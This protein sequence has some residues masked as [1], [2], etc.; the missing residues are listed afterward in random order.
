MTKYESSYGARRSGS[1]QRSSRN[2]EAAVSMA[3]PVAS[4]LG[5]SMQATRWSSRGSSR[6]AAH[7]EAQKAERRS[8]LRQ[9]N[10]ESYSSDKTHREQRGTSKM[11]RSRTV[12]RDLVALR[13]GLDTGASRDASDARDESRP[14]RRAGS[15]HVS[16]TT[17]SRTTA[18]R[19]TVTSRSV[20]GSRRSKARQDS[21]RDDR[22]SVRA[23]PAVY[24]ADVTA[25]GRVA[26][27]RT[28]NETSTTWLESVSERLSEVRLF[29][30]PILMIAGLVVALAVVIVMGPVRTYY[31]A[32]RDE[33]ILDA[34]YEVVAAQYEQ[35]SNEVD[36]LQT[37]EGIEE[38][39]RERGYVYPDEEALVV[40]GLEE[41]ESAEDVLLE[42]AVA[43]HEASQPWYVRMLDALFGYQHA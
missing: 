42:E 14:S 29:S 9:N 8:S 6:N 32:W 11:V 15:T 30:L 23:R 19:A 16:R 17:S 22:S 5:M 21:T 40:T 28:Q 35:L 12:R 33:G 37:R 31:A 27:S 25:D 2:G 41:E 39:A 1:R 18:S 10:V 43:E 34:Q 4:V 24:T 36:R 7:E 20:S 13:G 3:V 26:R 38:A